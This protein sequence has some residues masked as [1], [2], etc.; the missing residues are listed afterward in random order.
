M[1]IMTKMTDVKSHISKRG[2][3]LAL[4]A[5]ASATLTAQV[6]GSALDYMLQRPRVSKVYQHKRPFDHLFVDAGAGLNGMGTSS[7]RLGAQGSFGLGDWITPEHGVRMNVDGG[8]WKVFGKEN[9]STV[10]ALGEVG[11]GAFA[12][13]L[14]GSS[15]CPFA[16]DIVLMWSYDPATSRALY[17]TV[18]RHQA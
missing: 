17:D 5:L 8:L 2:A 11:A 1:K 12:Q 9:R 10:R 3:C 16:L 4:A 13:A 15:F 14:V 6:P 7:L 18:I